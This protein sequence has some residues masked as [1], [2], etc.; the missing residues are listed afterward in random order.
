M[1][2]FSWSNILNSNAF[3]F[4]VMVLFFAI[5]IKYLKLPE[6]I[7]NQRADIQQTVEASDNMKKAAKEALEKVEKSLETLPA[8][9]DKILENANNASKAFEAKSKEEIEKLVLSIKETANR[10]VAAEEKQAQS[11]LSKNIGKASVDIANRQVKTAFNNNSE[12]H[13]KFISDF[14]NSIDKLEV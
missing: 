4:A 1:L 3:N 9:I 7:E 13:R 12:L 11:V 10:Q 14:I 8:E 5:L 6:K 2:D